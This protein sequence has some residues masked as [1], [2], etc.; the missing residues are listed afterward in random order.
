MASDLVKLGSPLDWLEDYK[1]KGGEVDANQLL[2][3]GVNEH[4]GIGGRVKRSLESSFFTDYNPNLMRFNSTYVARAGQSATS[5]LQGAAVQSPFITMVP[6]EEDHMMRFFDNCPAWDLNKNKIDNLVDVYVSSE[7]F[8]SALKEFNELLM[9]PNGVNASLSQFTSAFEACAYDLILGDEDASMFCSVMS[10]EIVQVNQYITDLTKY[11]Q[12]GPGFEIN[13]NFTAHLFRDVVESIERGDKGTLRFAHAE[14]VIPFLS[15]IGLFD[16]DGRGG[17][18]SPKKRDE[19]RVFKSQKFFPFAA[20]VIVEVYDCEGADGE[21]KVL[22]FLV[23]ENEVNTVRG[24]DLF[25]LSCE[26]AE[27]SSL[28]SADR[29]TTWASKSFKVG[30]WRSFIRYCPAQGKNNLFRKGSVKCAEK[31][32]CKTLRDLDLVT[33]EFEDPLLIALCFEILEKKYNIHGLKNKYL[34]ET[35]KGPP[36][37]HMKLDI[38]NGWL[39]KVKMLFRDI[40]LTKKE[41][42]KFYDVNR[43]DGPFV[44][45]VKLFKCLEDP[46]EKQRDEDSK[47]L[48][49]LQSGGEE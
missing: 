10:E 40:L 5:F 44:V 21:E 18:L 7:E 19:D 2:P 4:M 17:G 31:E 27:V 41:L 12:Y 48:S 1:Y 43:A 46:G 47:Y 16:T 22:T 37:H 49:G 35:F 38:K 8:Q 34:Q 14:T 13:R 30:S 36:N 26:T 25:L 45:A 42:H 39:C 15:V 28:T 6:V 32:L 24:S 33:F 9:L 3:L 29:E 11:Y 20:N 23:N